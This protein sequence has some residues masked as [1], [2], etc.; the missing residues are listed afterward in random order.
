MDIETSRAARL[1][2]P[3]P[4]LLLVF[5]EALANALDAGA[6]KVAIT[7]EIDAFDAPETLRIIFSD[8]GA[9]FTEENFDRFKTI[10][11]P[12]DKY[13]KGVGRLVF[14][15]YFSTVEITSRWDNNERHF[16]FKDGFDGNAPIKKVSTVNE[17]NTKLI[18]SS[19]LKEK[20]KSYDDIEANAL[21]NSIIEHFFPTF[22]KL[23]RENRY[24]EIK[25]E[26][27]T[28][29]ANEQ[30]SFFPD[31]TTITPDDLPK[32]T[33]VIIQSQLMEEQVRLLDI[34]S[35]ISMYYYI[36]STDGKGHHMVAF[37]VDGRTIPSTLI[38][39]SSFPSGYSCFF[40]FESDMFD[41]NSDNARQQL[42]LPENISH[43]LFYSVLRKEVSKVLIELVP[44]IEENN[45][46][47][48]KQLED[49]F[50]HL[51]GYFESETAGLI[52][53]DESL[54]V[55]QQR[56]FLAQK[57]VLQSHNVSEFIYEKSMELSSRALT[58]YI[59]YRERIID[60]LKNITENDSEA[61]IHNLI[62]PRFRSLDQNS[63][64][65]DI[66]QNNAWLLDD[67]FMVFRTILSERDMNEVVNAI[68]LD[69]ELTGEPGRPDITM[70]FSADPSD[71]LPV[72][73]VVV[74]IKKKTSNEKENQY[75]INQLLERAEKLAKYCN[76]IQR[77]WYYAVIQIDD[78][79]A[80]RLEQQKWAPLFSKGKVY[81]QD[82]IAKRPDG[83][84]V[85]TPVFAISFDAI[86]EDAQSRNHV[87]LEILKAGIRKFSKDNSTSESDVK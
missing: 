84:I 81:Y 46:R 45:T 57:E 30:K 69:E 59:L 41:T 53:H 20:I 28:L 58:E 31:E 36:H 24:F 15:R 51:L 16:V 8:N 3:N 61:S 7:I 32:M 19:F 18:F 66:Y 14:L 77:I 62:V 23:K 40:F 76:N 72:D 12:R 78:S 48:K 6:T 13:H 74:E 11:K 87:F 9:G 33:E 60:R 22:Q 82:Y 1:F 2:F 35:D 29:K 64:S 34:N 5:F 80:S 56:F 4:S 26:L 65:S 25:I 83:S 37:S 85:P 79:F 38:P 52:D 47:V 27:K 50:P 43:A 54:H 71:S 39:Q 63:M 70:I 73:V 68:K 86:I 75:A 44:E 10:L 42:I 49:T 67:K 17:N 55:A 21:R